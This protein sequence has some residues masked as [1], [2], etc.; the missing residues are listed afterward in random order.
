[1]WLSHDRLAKSDIGQ[2]AVVLALIDEPLSVQIDHDA[3]RIG[4]FLEIIKHGTV[5][6]RRGADVPSDR[7][8]S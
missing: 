4:V 7:M 8:A 2:I 6:E 3:K 5:A 1:M